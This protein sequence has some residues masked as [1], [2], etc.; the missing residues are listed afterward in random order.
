[1][2]CAIS[3]EKLQDWFD[4][5]GTPGLPP[6]L[7]S[8]VRECTDCRGYVKRWNAIELGLQS[9]RLDSSQPSVDIA[10]AVR[11]RIQ[12]PMQRS[13]R[14]LTF[15][16]RRLALVGATA[17]A[18]MAAV[19]LALWGARLFAPASHTTAST[20]AIMRP[21]APAHTPGPAPGLPS[22]LPLAETR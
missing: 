9:M 20:L 12:S 21:A 15:P 8:H 3:R 11:A 13:E 18:A 7:A 10:A 1:M 4:Q 17:A 6:D 22:D 14:W 16:A 2:R 5:P 19:A